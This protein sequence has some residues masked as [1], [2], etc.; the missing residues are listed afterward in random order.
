[1]IYIATPKSFMPTQPRL[2]WVYRGLL[3]L[4]MFG[5]LLAC[6]T[7]KSADTESMAAE[8]RE[9]LKKMADPTLSKDARDEL[10]TDELNLS[11]KYPPDAGVPKDS[12]D[13]TIIVPLPDEVG[14]LHRSNAPYTTDKG[15]DYYYS[16]VNYSFTNPADNSYEE[17][18][19]VLVDTGNESKWKRAAKW[20]TLVSYASTNPQMTKVVD[21]NG[22]TWIKYLYNQTGGKHYSEFTEELFSTLIDNRFEAIICFKSFD[23]SNDRRKRIYEAGLTPDMFYKIFDKEAIKRLSTL[24]IKEEQ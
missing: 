3:L 21:A 7:K 19:F 5:S 9:L 2:S 23:V 1:M 12:M 20:D 6:S 8:G 14:P 13:K 24:T 10:R 22:T 11:I 17:L 16:N 18:Y 15:G 4:F